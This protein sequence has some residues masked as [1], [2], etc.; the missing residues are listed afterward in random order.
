MENMKIIQFHNVL[1]EQRRLC[2]EDIEENRGYD[3][4][5]LEQEYSELE[6]K[7]DLVQEYFNCIDSIEVLEDSVYSEYYPYISKE[8]VL[9]YM[10]EYKIKLCSLEEEILSM[11]EE[12][13]KEEE[14]IGCKENQANQLAHTCI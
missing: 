8:E 13:E 5:D 1:M 3:V 2:K 10:K 14:C 6:K 9:S 7:L 12:E 4:S 11:I